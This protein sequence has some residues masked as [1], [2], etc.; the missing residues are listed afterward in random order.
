MTMYGINTLIGSDQRC[1]PLTGEVTHSNS[2]LVAM[3]SHLSWTFQAKGDFASS[4]P[5]KLGLPISSREKGRQKQRES[6]FLTMLQRKSVR[7]GKSVS[8]KYSL[9]DISPEICPDSRFFGGSSPE[10]MRSQ[11]GSSQASAQRS[12]KRSTF[13]TEQR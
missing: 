6:V 8:W 4:P 5:M 10:G 13:A 3:N 11:K 12:Q 2:A 1:N 9:R 7:L